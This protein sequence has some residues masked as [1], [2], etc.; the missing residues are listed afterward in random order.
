MTRWLC[1]VLP[2]ELAA[3]PEQTEDALT[4]GIQGWLLPVQQNTVSD[5]LRLLSDWPASMQLCLELLE[6]ECPLDLLDQ[7]LFHP[8]RAT[9]QGRP[10]L[11]VRPDGE[12]PVAVLDHLGLHQVAVFGPCAKKEFC[13]LAGWIPPADSNGLLN[14]AWFLKRAHFR[15]AHPDLLLPAVRALDLD[16]MDAFVAADAEMYQA[17]LQLESAW[18]ALQVNG[19][20]DATVLIDSWGGHQRWWGPEQTSSATTCQ[21]QNPR[22]RSGSE[23]QW[24]V[25]HPSHLAI[26]IH[27]F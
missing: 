19:E 21:P 4:L 18:S 22:E 3:L 9:F 7:A 20:E 24:G 25:M 2:E 16:Q 10:M 8:S 6:L 11:L 15:G 12:F 14:Y 13:G 27:G 23:R 5:L 26:A 17:W 1:R